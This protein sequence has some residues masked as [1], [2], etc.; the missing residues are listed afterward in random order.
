MERRHGG[1]RKKG[2]RLL[3]ASP[4]IEVD[5]ACHEISDLLPGN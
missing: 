2:G 1:E 5:F 3:N 4:R